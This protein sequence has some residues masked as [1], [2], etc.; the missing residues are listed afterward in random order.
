[1]VAL[2]AFDV[3]QLQHVFGRQRLEIQAVGGV[4]VGRDRLGV[5]VDHD[6]LDADV[7]KGE[8]GVAAAVVE[9]DALTD[10]V[11]AAAEDH[12]LP[13]VGGLGLAGRDLAQGAGLIGRIHIGGGGGELGGAGV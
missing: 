2:G 4:V 13:A 11:G 3:D 10:A 8:G 1:Q 9:L 5:A 6:R 7:G 12:G